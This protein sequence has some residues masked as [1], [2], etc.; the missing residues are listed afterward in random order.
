MSSFEKLP[1]EVLENIFLQ[2][3]NY[4]LPRSSPVLAGRLSSNYTYVQT[5]INGLGVSW[6]RRFIE[7]IESSV[8]DIDVL[9]V[10]EDQVSRP[11]S[12]VSPR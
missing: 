2:S 9:Q 12:Q 7:G 8:D 3:M 4:N 10:A 5:I 6:R 11:S 1:T